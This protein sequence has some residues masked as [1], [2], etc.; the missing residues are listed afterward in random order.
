MK[1]ATARTRKELSGLIMPRL[2]KSKTTLLP[3][4]AAKSNH[5][6]AGMTLTQLMPPSPCDVNFDS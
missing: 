5:T 6:H 3:W 4:I 2:I 1:R